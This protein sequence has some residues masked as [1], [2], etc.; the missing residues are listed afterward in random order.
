MKKRTLFCIVALL[1]LCSSCF[2]TSL[3][4]KQ[5]I[6]R[7]PEFKDAS[8]VDEITL[9]ENNHGDHQVVS[10]QYHH[11][12]KKRINGK[13][14]YFHVDV[15]GLHYKESWISKRTNL[16]IDQPI[17]FCMYDSTLGNPKNYTLYA[18]NYAYRSGFELIYERYPTFRLIKQLDVRDFTY[19]IKVKNENLR[20]CEFRKIIIPEGYQNNYVMSD[21][22]DR[23]L[24]REHIEVCKDE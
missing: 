14:G 9:Y 24:F 16:E 6:K 23:V 7:D 12:Y 8:F 5:I 19:I 4:S 2:L 1:F 11:I 21:K 3:L 15:T 22:N 17:R 20:V 18:K 10:L 13:C